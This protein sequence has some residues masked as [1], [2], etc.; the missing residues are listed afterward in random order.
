MNTTT[1]STGISSGDPD[2]DPDEVLRYLVILRE[3]GTHGFAVNTALAE[4]HTADTPR[5][6]VAAL[7][8][9]HTRLRGMAAVT[10]AALATPP[11]EGDA[12]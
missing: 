4:A 3:L 6:R 8:T 10:N 1:A 9:L 7:T 2:P 12:R 11:D 5:R